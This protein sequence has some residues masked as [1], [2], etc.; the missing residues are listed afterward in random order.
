MDSLGLETY[1]S[2]SWMSETS[3]LHSKST[4]AL[5]ARTARLRRGIEGELSR[6]SHTVWQTS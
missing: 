4:R 5:R 3:F 1:L 6:E 2:W